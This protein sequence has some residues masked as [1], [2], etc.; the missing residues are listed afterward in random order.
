VKTYHIELQ[1]LKAMSHGNGLIDA[2]ID[3]AVLPVSAAA[4][5][6]TPTTLL[7]MTEAT[8]RVLQALLKIQLAELDKRKARSQR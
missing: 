8:A 7:R 1:R 3:A 2:Q 6:A 4:D 5:G